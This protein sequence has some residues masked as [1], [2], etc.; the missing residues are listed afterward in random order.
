ML[1]VTVACMLPVTVACMLPVTVACMLPVT[2]ACM[3]SALNGSSALQR[4]ERGNAVEICN[5]ML[6]FY[7]G[8]LR[9]LFIVSVRLCHRTLETQYIDILLL[10]SPQ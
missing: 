10:W 7:L 9:K 1:P 8:L 3:R 6:D 4:F 2:V 5:R